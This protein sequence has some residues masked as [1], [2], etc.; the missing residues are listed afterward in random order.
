[1]GRLSDSR[2]FWL[3][4]SAD[5]TLGE[6]FLVAANKIIFISSRLFYYFASVLAGR[7]T[8]VIY[9]YRRHLTGRPKGRALLAYLPEVVYKERFL[10]HVKF[11]FSNNG[12]P[13]AVMRA[14]NELG[15]A[16][17]IISYQYASFVP[18]EKYDLFFF[19]EYGIYDA[20]K[21][22]L[23]PETVCILFE[24]TAYWQ[25]MVEN[26]RARLV[27][28]KQRHS[29]DLPEREYNHFF[30]MERQKEQVKRVS[31]AADGL[32]VMGDQLAKTFQRL[33]NPGVR[34]IKSA[35]FQDK[36]FLKDIGIANLDKHRRNFLFF[37]GGRDV[38]RKGLD[39]LLDAFIG[40]PYQLF[41]CIDMPEL[42][43]KIYRL[44]GRPN[45]HNLGYLKVGS[46]KFYTT[47]NECDFVIQ[48]SAAEGVPG[49]VLETMKYGLIP[50]V[51][52]ECNMPE[53]EQAGCLLPAATVEEVRQ[54]IARMACLPAE[55]LRAKARQTI[56]TISA[57]YTPRNFINDIKRAT[58]EIVSRKAN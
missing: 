52:Q 29:V 34:L 45:I 49:G 30:W 2:M 28:F 55:Q 37:G 1:M 7:D 6:L 50:I 56:A 44:S 23:G 8:N 36:K 14:L 39:I 4:R 54:A 20:L 3:F 57:V 25:P 48:P 46:K 26:I 24:T 51:S 5:L 27:Y 21:P 41:M 31:E 38:I 16:V 32:V 18:K 22:K 35:V 17:D 33:K 47:L 53:A 13:L 15:Y 12:A 10:G 43:G 40:T 42:F 58:S 11:Y 9:N 19:H